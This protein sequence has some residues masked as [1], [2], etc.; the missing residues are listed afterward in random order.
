MKQ[1]L[2][3]SGKFCAPCSSFKPTIDKI[4]QQLNVVYIDVDE[5]NLVVAEY[6]VRSVPTLIFLRDNRMVEKRSGVMSEQQI[7]QIY[8]SL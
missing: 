5:N 2:Y 3:F 1:I 8:N 7:M 4:S 6:G